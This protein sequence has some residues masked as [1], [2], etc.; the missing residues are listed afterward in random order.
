MN[1]NDRAITALVALAHGLVH[2]Y[3][4][5]IPI[6]MTIWLTTF[7]VST[8]TLGLAV[9]T[10][11]AL[12]GLGAL[13]GGIW[14]DRVGARP[15]IVGCAAGMGG[16]FLLLSVAQSLW[17]ISGALMLW[18]AAASVYH[19]AGLSLVSTG[20]QQR[21]HVLALHGM[22][23]NAGIALGPLA[24][25]VLLLFMDWRWVAVALA[26]PAFAAAFYAWNASF[27]A[28][29]AETRVPSRA[30]ST[31]GSSWA[32]LWQSSRTLLATS[33]AAVF[34][35]VMCSGLFYRGALTFLPDML[36]QLVTF[37]LPLNL[38]AGRYIYAGLLIVGMAGQYAG[39]RLTDRF[40]TEP[41]IAVALGLL[42]VV[43]A[44][45]YPVAQ[46]STVALIGMSALLGFLLF[47]VQPLYQATVAEH[48]PTPLR[49]LS[50]G[51]TYLGVFG[52]GALG[53]ALTGWLL[54]RY[55]PV[56][57]FG[58][59]ALI[60]LIGSAIAAGLALFPKEKAAAPS[61]DP[62]A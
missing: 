37:R 34:A 56:V 49:G 39:G 57:M 40:R 28:H 8:G 19:P 30:A 51:F 53:A 21:G 14:T 23:G 27:D 52:V 1:A 61:T 4:L 24:A 12:F 42:A 44:V 5:S 6:F 15:L 26:L 41:A 29:A 33:F 60:A 35:I 20:A 38:E 55:T 48:T 36:E 16:A 31:K 22:A 62:A 45:F 13:P 32:A 17:T 18:G 10:G 9:S 58:V 3:E 43:G 2:T 50:Y 7:D 59:L 54:A 25:T 47:L 46:L 11:Y